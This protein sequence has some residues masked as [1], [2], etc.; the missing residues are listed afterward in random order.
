MQR[1]IDGGVPAALTVEFMDEDGYHKRV[2]NFDDE[3]IEYNKES[4]KDAMDIL[5]ARCTV[6]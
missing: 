4:F 1:I 6:E 5:K 3:D 2:I